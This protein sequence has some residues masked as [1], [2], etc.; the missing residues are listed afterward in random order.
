MLTLT[1]FVAGEPQQELEARALRVAQ[2]VAARYPDRVRV[3]TQLLA[4]ERAEALGLRM[5][6]TVVEGD[7]VLSVG[8][9]LSAGRLK[10]Y[11]EL[12]LGELE[13]QT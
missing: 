4:S 12:R 9:E 6:P 11:V 8:G 13:P 1:V 3:E 7:L 5:A 10:R 2:A